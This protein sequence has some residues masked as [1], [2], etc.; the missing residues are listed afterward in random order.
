M[1]EGNFELN[2]SLITTAVFI[3]SAVFVLDY[4]KIISLMLFCI[5]FGIT[6]GIGIFATKWKQKK[7][8]HKT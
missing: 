2:I 3:L 8:E 5:A 1:K 4:N 7:Q 6:I